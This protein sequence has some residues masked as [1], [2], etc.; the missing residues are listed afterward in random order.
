MFAGALNHLAALTRVGL[1]GLSVVA[2][3]S[4][5]AAVYGGVEFPGG[6]ASFAD[7][8]VSYDPT[9][10]GTAGPDAA[11]QTPLNA[12]GAPSSSADTGFVTLGQGGRI[13]LRFSD[14]S[15]TGSGS[16]ALD[17]W[18]FEVGPDVEDTFVDISKDGLLW[19][20]VGKVFGA[21]AGI[22]IDAFG[23][24][25]L[26]KFSYI[27]LT[28]DPQEG[29]TGAGGSVGADIDAV[30]AITSAPPVNAVPE[31]NSV[32]LTALALLGLALTRR[33]RQIARTAL[34]I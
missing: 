16:A 30:G 5:H 29:Q 21:T 10:G 4:A 27:R 25:V 17:L 12:L 26:D 2:G 19:F 11:Y 14:N 22:D 6:A 31:P 18:V 24:G 33:M 9:Y 34:R 23:F 20:S 1:A 7:S 32:V 28:D 15:L 13:V 8:L 3:V